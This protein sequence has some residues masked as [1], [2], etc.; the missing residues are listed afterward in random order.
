MLSPAGS[1]AGALVM[2]AVSGSG[3]TT[4]SALMLKQ[5]FDYLGDELALLTKDFSCLSMPVGLGVKR[6]SY[7][8]LA[9][10]YTELAA[11]PEWCRPTGLHV[12]YLSVPSSASYATLVS[13]EPLPVKAWVFPRYLA[14]LSVTGTVKGVEKHASDKRLNHLQ[15][16]SVTR[17][18]SLMFE[19]GM[20]TA[21]DFGVD[22][23]ADLLQ[24]LSSTPRFEIVFDDAQQLIVQLKAL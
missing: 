24:H 22:Q 17:A 5:G 2:P 12:K 19:A 15:A 10:D 18:L 9:N 1:K 20:H 4:L 8:P 23:L 14:P 7:L 6:G 11:L 13:D 21:T 3:K 16:I